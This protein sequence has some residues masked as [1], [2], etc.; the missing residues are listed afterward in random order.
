MPKSLP[1]AETVRRTFESPA[2]NGT[3]AFAVF[4][5]DVGGRD[6]S[7]MTST[8]D[9]RPARRRRQKS[10]HVAGD[11]SVPSAVLQAILAHRRR[12][13]SSLANWLGSADAEDVLQE[14]CLKALQKGGSLRRRESA[15]VWFE[16]IVR[17]AAIDHARHADAERRARAGLARDPTHGA[18]VVLPAH[19]REPICRC[20]LGLLS[21]LRPGYADV[22]RRVDLGGERIADVAATFG[23]SPNSVRV[24]LHRARTALRARW[25][26]FCGLCARR[27]GRFC[28]CDDERLREAVAP[29]RHRSRAGRL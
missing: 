3:E 12:L 9:R 13:T 26:E 17:H 20:G 21:T 4:G 7:P 22:L 16:R 6:G 11:G 18:E 15:L 24:R 2:S 5:S 29:R 1:L 8:S 28:D 23:A 27:G 25:L 19:L 10:G 14:A